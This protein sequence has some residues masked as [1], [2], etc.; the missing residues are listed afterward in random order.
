MTAM[1]NS[2]NFVGV[3]VPLAEKIARDSIKT[4]KDDV[5]PTLQGYVKPA[6]V[7]PENT[8]ESLL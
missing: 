1:Y 5:D 8:S 2:D 4:K 7:I 3:S 6:R